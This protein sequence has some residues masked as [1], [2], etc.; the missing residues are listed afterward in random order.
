[1][2]TMSDRNPEKIARFETFA[3]AFRLRE[4]GPLD[5]AADA[6]FAALQKYPDHAG[7]W[8]AL[9]DVLTRLKL[10]GAAADVLRKA[11]ELRPTKHMISGAL[12]TALLSADRPGDAIV[13][14]RRFLA[15]DP[16]VAE[17][18][19]ELLSVYRDWDAEGEELAVEWLRRVRE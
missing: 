6:F 19:E 16:A 1:M 18:D 14:A 9:G 15:L 3:D 4:S 17:R 10:Y 11:V 7:G 13:E 5:K 8:I 2:R 12:F